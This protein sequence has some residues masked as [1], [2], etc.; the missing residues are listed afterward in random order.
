L[1]KLIVHTAYASVY[2]KDVFKVRLDVHSYTDTKLSLMPPCFNF[3][4]TAKICVT[5]KAFLFGE[6][7]FEALF[8]FTTQY[9]AYFSFKHTYSFGYY[10]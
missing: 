7:E 8:S 9:L 5:Y 3:V 1:Q 2:A 10:R 6:K 4:Y